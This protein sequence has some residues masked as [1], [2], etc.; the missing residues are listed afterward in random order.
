MGLMELLM[1]PSQMENEKREGGMW[2]MT[3]ISNRLYRMQTALMMFSVKKG[4]QQNRKTAG[5][6]QTYSV[7]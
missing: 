4:T 5:Q 1:Y 6:T 2:Q 3:D 7:N